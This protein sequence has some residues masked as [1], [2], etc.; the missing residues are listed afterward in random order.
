MVCICHGGASLGIDVKLAGANVGDRFGYSVSSA[1]DLNNDGTYDDVIIGA[2]YN[3]ATGVDAGAIYVFY[4]SSSMTDTSA[5]NADNISYGKSTGEH[6]GWSVSRAGDVNNDGW[7]D[8]I[9]GAPGFDNN[10]YVDAGKAYVMTYYEAT[11]IPEFGIIVIPIFITLI[12][13]AIFRRKYCGKWFNGS[14]NSPT[15]CNNCYIRMI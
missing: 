10:T 5:S 9:I 1:G 7:N 8:A 12:I 2:P 13:I 14:K 15:S 3:D 4:G 11:V 6:F